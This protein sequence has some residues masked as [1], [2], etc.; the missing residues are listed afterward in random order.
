[1]ERDLHPAV[2]T[3][4]KKALRA[5]SLRRVNRGNY[6]G[7]H[8]CRQEVS[9]LSQSRQEWREITPRECVFFSFLSELDAYWAFSV[10]P[11]SLSLKNK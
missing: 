9:L 2:T 8:Y 11:F 3:V 4:E 1:M 6:G 10:G 5:G 7:I